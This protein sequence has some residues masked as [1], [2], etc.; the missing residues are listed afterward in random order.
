MDDTLN[1]HPMWVLRGGA[2]ATLV[3]AMFVLGVGVFA[4]THQ[5]D[6]LVQI[7]VVNDTE[8]EAVASLD[9]TQQRTLG[10]G[11][12]L[13]L[14]QTAVGDHTVRVADTGEHAL[15]FALEFHTDRWG[16]EFIVELADSGTEA[17]SHP[18]LRPQAPSH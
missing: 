8:A 18:T 15:Q 2:F 4:L 17:R 10:P 14:T 16:D 9:E 13:K 6:P 3:V 12:R 5:P 1:T 11:E 7:T